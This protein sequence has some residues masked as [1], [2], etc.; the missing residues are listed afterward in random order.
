M[1]QELRILLQGAQVLTAFLIVLPFS[2]GFRRIQRV[3][4]W[5]YVATF[6]CSLV[7]LVILSAPAAQHRLQRPL[8]DRVQ[9]KQY[10]TRLILIGLVP[11]S[12]ALILSTHLV[13]AEVLGIGLGIAV[14]S[15]V[16][17]LI[18]GLWWWMPVHRKQKERE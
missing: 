8:I 6:L 18:A 17:L 2:E 7:S 12:L 16:A 11:L 14:A 3:E 13:V 4:K 9:F 1:L 10:A 15:I 5:V